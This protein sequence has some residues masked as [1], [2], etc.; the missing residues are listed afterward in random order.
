MTKKNECRVVADAI[1]AVVPGFTH[2]CETK[3]CKK[4][5]PVLGSRIDQYCT[6]KNGR[7]TRTT[8]NPHQYY[9]ICYRMRTK[10]IDPVLPPEAATNT[11]A[12][13]NPDPPGVVGGIMLPGAF[14]VPKLEAAAAEIAV[15]NDRV[16]VHKYV[17]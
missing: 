12:A 4:I 15:A 3:T 17:H 16:I 8:L 6:V 1:T 2:S 10:V 13:S 9:S 7:R 5:V 14:T 11:N